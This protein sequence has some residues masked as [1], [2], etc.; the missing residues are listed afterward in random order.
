[1]GPEAPLDLATVSPVATGWAVAPPGDLLAGLNWKRSLL[2]LPPPAS[3]PAT[4]VVPGAAVAV[5]KALPTLSLA[6]L[7]P[8][9]KLLPE[10]Q[11]LPAASWGQLSVQM[12]AQAR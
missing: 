1:M 2:L 4:L 11:P 10:L 8:M 6:A 12:A 7:G 9:A 3:P 5:K